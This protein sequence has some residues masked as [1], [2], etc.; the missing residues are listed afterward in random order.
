MQKNKCYIFWDD[1]TVA[2]AEKKIY[3]Q[4]EKCHEKNKKGFPWSANILYGRKEIKCGLC[5]TI[6]YQ[7]KRKKKE[8]EKNNT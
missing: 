7:S 5:N 1:D 4:C 6:I 8:N 3:V 2:K